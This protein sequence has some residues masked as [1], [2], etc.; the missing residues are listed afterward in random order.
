MRTTIFS[1]VTATLVTIA[2]SA[3]SA[4][5]L[6]ST[7]IINTAA[8]GGRLC[9]GVGASA[10]WTNPTGQTSYIKKAQIWQMMALPNQ[11]G[12]VGSWIARVSDG[13]LLIV[14]P[15]DFYANP[16]NTTTVMQNRLAP[17]YMSLAPGGQL[18][19]F[20]TCSSGNQPTPTFYAMFNVWYTV[21]AP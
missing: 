2:P 7:T 13:A 19:A 12:D 9:N 16:N 20:Y 11:Q 18:Q 1:I 5:N 6:K 15:Q 10:Y 14:Y 3:F 21:G 8:N 4:G 17:D